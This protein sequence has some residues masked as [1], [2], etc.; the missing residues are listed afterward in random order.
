MLKILS[1]KQNQLKELNIENLP[2]LTYLL[3]SGNDFKEITLS[4]VSH[5]LEVNFNKVDFHLDSKVTIH[6]L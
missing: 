6:K 5:K 3:C 4:N 1:V 2:K